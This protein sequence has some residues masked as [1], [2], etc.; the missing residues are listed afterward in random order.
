MWPSSTRLP[1]QNYSVLSN[2]HAA[3]THGDTS[4]YGTVPLSNLPGFSHRPSAQC[5]AGE[6]GTTLITQLGIDMTC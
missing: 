2:K 5:P 6:S 3:S 4:H 1:E